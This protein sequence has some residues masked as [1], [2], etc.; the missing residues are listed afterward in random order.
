MLLSLRF[1][2]SVFFII[3]LGG[4]YTFFV[5]N[6]RPSVVEVVGVVLSCP[7][8]FKSTWLCSYPVACFGHSSAVARLGRFL[9]R[10]RNV[11]AYLA[12]YSALLLSGVLGTGS[13]ICQWMM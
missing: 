3:F 12:G 4:L 10:S 6:L 1:S 7:W 11:F 13:G 5:G 9:L 2:H 8:T